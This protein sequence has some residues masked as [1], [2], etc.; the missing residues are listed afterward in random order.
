MSTAGV[1]RNTCGSSPLTLLT[2]G[3][4]TALS[5]EPSAE[6]LLPLPDGS[7][8]VFLPSLPRPLACDPSQP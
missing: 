4:H 6:Q 5:L 1:Y 2:V 8:S 3:Y 7:L